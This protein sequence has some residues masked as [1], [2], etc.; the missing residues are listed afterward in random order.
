LDKARPNTEH[1]RG[2]NLAAVMCTT[3]QMSRLP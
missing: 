3:I 1:I 2:L